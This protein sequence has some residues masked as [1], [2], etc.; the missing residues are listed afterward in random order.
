[1]ACASVSAESQFPAVKQ[2][3][4]GLSAGN[5]VDGPSRRPN[6]S[7]R[8]VD[9]NHDRFRRTHLEHLHSRVVY[10]SK[11]IIAKSLAAL[12]RG[13]RHDYRPAGLMLGEHLMSS[14]RG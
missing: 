12:A 13:T 5:L 2:P 1:M 8:P 4:R 6:S 7:L 3:Q 14:R 9:P 10:V 11:T